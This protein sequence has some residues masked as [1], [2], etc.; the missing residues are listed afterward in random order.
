VLYKTYFQLE[1]HNQRNFP[2]GGPFIIATNHASHLDAGAMISAV[3]AAAGVKE[4]RKL[5]VLGARDYFFNTPFKSWLFST[6]LNL[7]PVEREETSLAGIRMVKSILSAGE[8]VL[9]FPEGTRSR[10]GEIQ[11]FKPGV[12]LIAL[13]LGV[14][15]VPA[16]IGGTYEALPAGK[17]FPRRQRIRVFFGPVIRVEPDRSQG[18]RAA[19]DERYRQIAAEVRTA[20]VE[21]ANVSSPE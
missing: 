14:P 11:E 3:S 13:E 17:F 8:S 12:G 18:A 10:T 9:I 5:H 19:A 15:V 2:P 21:L 20:I 1:L 6:F 4:A 16:Y 7:V